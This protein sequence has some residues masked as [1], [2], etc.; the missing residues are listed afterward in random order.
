[1]KPERRSSEL[2]RTALGNDRDLRARGTSLRG[3]R[4][5][6]DNPELLNSEAIQEFRVITS[7]ANAAQGRSAG[8]QVSVVTKSGTN[9]FGGSAFWFHRPTRL[10]ANDFF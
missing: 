4:V 6:G 2:I 3:V 10:S 7:N 1:M 9:Q 5:A 8:A